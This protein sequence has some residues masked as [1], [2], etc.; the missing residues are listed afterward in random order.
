PVPPVTSNTLSFI[1]LRVLAEQV[2]RLDQMWPLRRDIPR[3]Q[4]K[5]R[6]VERAIDDDFVVRRDFARRPIRRSY[7]SQQIILADRVRGHVKDSTEARVGD[8]E[9]AH[10]AGKLDGRKAGEDGPAVAH[11]SP[12]F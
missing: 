10:H 6:G 8:N 5:L 11:Y 12:T 1:M 3:G 2:H 4:T 9:V 7:Q